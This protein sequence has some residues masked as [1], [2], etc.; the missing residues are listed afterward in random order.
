MNRLP[1]PVEGTLRR[2]VSFREL[3]GAKRRLTA[4]KSSGLKVAP[5]G[6][7]VQDVV[8]ITKNSSGYSV[9]GYGLVKKKEFAPG[10]IIKWIFKG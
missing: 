3:N 6:S 5:W 4:G 10:D 8:S 9:N 2:F 1:V 7:D